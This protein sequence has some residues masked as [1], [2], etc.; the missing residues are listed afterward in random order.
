MRW[1]V[2]AHNSHNHLRGS[3]DHLGPGPDTRSGGDHMIDPTISLRGLGAFLLSRAENKLLFPNAEE[4]E[5]VSSQGV[6]RGLHDGAQCYMI[7]TH[8]EVERGEAMSV[9]PIV[10]DFGD[11]FSE[12]VPRLPPSR[13][14]EFSIDLVLGTGPMS[15]APYRMALAELVE[16][17]K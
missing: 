9:I 7:F 13:E 6:M 5:L 10:Q 14:V 16:L 1:K 3:V 8:M 4:P 12:E 17:K 15:M 2:S 11:V